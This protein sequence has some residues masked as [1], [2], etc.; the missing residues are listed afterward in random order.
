M[1]HALLWTPGNLLSFYKEYLWY[2]FLL[3][4]AVM[5]YTY[6]H[7]FGRNILNELDPVDDQKFIYDSDT[8]TYSRTNP[9]DTFTG[10]TGLQPHE[11]PRMEQQESS[12]TE[13]NGQ[14]H[15]D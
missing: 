9:V 13:Y 10:H 4:C 15:E 5:A 12:K 14:Q 2:V 7:Y 3:D 1:T 6:K 8:H 11:T